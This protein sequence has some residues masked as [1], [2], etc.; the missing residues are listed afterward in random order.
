MVR[1]AIKLSSLKT[2]LEIVSI[3][4]APS[5]IAATI[6]HDVKM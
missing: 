6:N 2:H 3:G 5:K 4:D 1:E